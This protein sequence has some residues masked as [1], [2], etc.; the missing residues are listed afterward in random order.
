V[1]AKRSNKN[2]RREKDRGAEKSRSKD[3]AR[4]R[5]PPRLVEEP[6]SVEALTVFWMLTALATLIAETIAAAALFAMAFS[7]D[8]GNSL[9]RIMPGVMLFTALV[10]GTICL[11]L[12][13]LVLRQ[14]RTPPPRGVVGIVILIGVSPWLMLAASLFRGR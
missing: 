10:T 3:E 1:A 2:R 12:T 7:P 6:R 4:R 9:L 5:I 13:P 14:R 11:A 8:L